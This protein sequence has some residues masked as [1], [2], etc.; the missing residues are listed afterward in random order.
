MTSYA[1]YFSQSSYAR[2]GL[3]IVAELRA[4]GQDVD[5]WGSNGGQSWGTP[6]VPANITAEVV[7]VAS[8][9]DAQRVK[10]IRHNPKV[11]YVE[12]GAGQTYQT[13]EDRL[14]FGYPGGPGLDHVA[15]FV[16]P[17]ERVADRWR[18]TYPTARVAV[19][20]CPALDRITRAPE[21]LVAVSRHWRCGVA[22]EAWPALPEFWGEIPALAKSLDAQGYELVGHAHPRDAR[23]LSEDWRDLG[24]RYEPDPD[25]ILSTASLLIVDNSSI[26][27]EAAAVGL[28]VLSLN[29][30]KWR[31]DIDCPPR[32]WNYVPGL[33]CDRPE[34]LVFMVDLALDDPEEAQRLRANAARFVYDKVDGLASVR[35]VEVI[36][37]LKG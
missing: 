14:G 16:C 5:V 24:I 1:A 37:C 23:R 27:Y 3:P 4:R 20:G 6:M 9:I 2:H 11:V 36:E 8:G 12:H 25:V 31:R 18:R 17:S 32:F 19:V 28:P 29:S 30:A 22:P 10:E 33:Q 21:P 15:L 35:A 34:D 26:A 13:D 7:I